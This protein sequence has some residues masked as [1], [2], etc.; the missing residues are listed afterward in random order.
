MVVHYH[1]YGDAGKV[2]TRVEQ[3]SQR[4]LTQISLHEQGGSRAA[5]S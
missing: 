3:H 2:P 5:R 1:A 4:I